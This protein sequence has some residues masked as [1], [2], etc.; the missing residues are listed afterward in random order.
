MKTQDADVKIKFLEEKV[1]AQSKEIVSTSRQ[2]KDEIDALQAKLDQA[3]TE[4]EMLMKFIQQSDELEN[5]DVETKGEHEGQN[6]ID[7]EDMKVLVVGGHENFLNKLRQRFPQWVI[8][9]DE[10][11]TSEPTKVDVVIYVPLHCGHSLY[12]KGRS[13]AMNTNAYELYTKSVNIEA[14]IKEVTHNLWKLLVNGSS[15]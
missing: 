12:A 11:F 14:F 3:K 8:P 5:V 15:D 7:L 10:L 13:V 4:A 2:K 1:N 6:D 9:G